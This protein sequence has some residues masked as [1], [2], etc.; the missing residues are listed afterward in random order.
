LGRI[1]A[2]AIAVHRGFER[3]DSRLNGLEAEVREVRSEVAEVRSGLAE[4]RSG[5]A[6]V[7]SGLAT[8]TID[9]RE[10]KEE[11]RG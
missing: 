3:V 9:M 1:D 5:L 10:V 8:L 6:E 2:L 11:V 4:V 7:R